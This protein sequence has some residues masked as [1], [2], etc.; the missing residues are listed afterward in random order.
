MML[1][2]RGMRFDKRAEK[3]LSGASDKFYS[4]VEK[5]YSYSCKKIFSSERSSGHVYCMFDTP[6]RYIF[7]I[8]PNVFRLQSENGSQLNFLTK[9]PFF[10][11]KSSGHV[12]CSFAKPAGNFGL[13]TKI[14]SL[15]VRKKIKKDKFSLESFPAK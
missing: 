11:E 13:K 3:I 10:M 12:E 2:A 5:I 8:L 4:K 7:F 15:K 6:V 14:S 9:N 1:S